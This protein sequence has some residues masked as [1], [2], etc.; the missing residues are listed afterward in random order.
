MLNHLI[1]TALRNRILVLAALA[2]LIGGGIF[3][4]L[5][6]PIDAFPDLTNNQITVI[7]DCP[8]CRPLRSNS[9]SPCRSKRRSWVC[10]AYRGALRLKVRAFHSHRRFRRHGQPLLRAPARQRA[11]AGGARRASRKAS[12]P[13]SA[14]RHALRRSLPVHHRRREGPLDERKA[15][16]D[17]VI[18]PLLRTVPGFVEVETWGG[19]RAVRDRGRPEALERYGLSLRDVEAGRRATKTSAAASSSSPASSTPSS[20]WAAPANTC[21]SRTIVIAARAG[22]PVLVRDVATIGTGAVPRQGATLRDGKGET[23]SGMAIM[24]KGENGMR[25]DRARQ[26]AAGEH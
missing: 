5:E 17:W 14:Q 24:L 3:S 19:R 8:A 9:S 22:T 18:R 7:T 26:G 23:V 12:N 1:D 15:F 21:R 20:A 4:L 11:A 6:L 25:R 10:P 2:L 13:A 16:L